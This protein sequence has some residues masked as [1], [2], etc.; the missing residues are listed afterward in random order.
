MRHQCMAETP[1]TPKQEIK[2]FYCYAHEDKA[3]RDELQVNL[4]GLRRQYRLTNWYDREILPGEKWKE[5]IDTPLYRR[6][7]PTTHQPALRRL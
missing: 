5:A 4:A 2:L 1:N 7:Y 6:C 3:L